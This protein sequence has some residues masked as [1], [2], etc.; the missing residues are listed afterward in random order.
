[1]CIRDSYECAP[2][3]FF[4][5][6]GLPYPCKA[7]MVDIFPVSYTHL[8]FKYKEGGWK[9]SPRRTRVD[10]ADGHF[11]VYEAEKNLF[12]YGYLS[13]NLYIRPSCGKCAFKGVPRQGDITFADFWGIDEKYDDDKG[14]S[15]CV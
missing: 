13:S 8:W 15:R 3:E 9:S 2:E 5:S 4:Q 14:T 7:F 1:M 12:M 11:K 10:F 6:Y